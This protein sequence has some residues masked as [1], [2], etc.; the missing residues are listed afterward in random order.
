ME[1]S[2]SL[3]I[4]G[5]VVNYGIR[6]GKVCGDKLGQ[7]VTECDY[8]ICN[9]EAP[10]EGVGKPI[11]KSGPHHYQRKSTLSGLKT[12][13]FN[14][15]LM[16][17]NHMMDFGVEGAIKTREAALEQGLDTIGFGLSHDEAYTPV[18]RVINGLKVGFVNACE[19]Q[20]GVLDY[21]SPTEEP[22]YAWINHSR[23]NKTIVTLKATCDFVIVL[24]HAG[25]EKYSIPQREWR[26]RY[27]HLCELGADAVIAAHPHVPQG[28]EA[29][30]DSL[31]FYSLGNFY[32]DSKN[33]KNKKDSSFAVKLKLTKNAPIDWEPVFYDKSTGLTEVTDT[34]VD[35]NELCEQLQEPRYTHLHEEMSLKAYASVKKNLKFSLSFGPLGLAWKSMAKRVL[36]I[37]LRGFSAMSKET[38]DTLQLHVLRNEAYYYAAKSALEIKYRKHLK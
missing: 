27:K 11:L 8:S 2:T 16:A 9:F 18:I 4:A 23:I 31:I 1:K 26:I 21:S 10:I 17:N 36:L 15:V 30:N 19:A 5:D 6:D 34:P 29:H 33:Y 32:F 3:F 12:Q 14:M 38:K 35:L 24:A 37:P 25:L 20:F 28:Y 7:I 22:G 13:G